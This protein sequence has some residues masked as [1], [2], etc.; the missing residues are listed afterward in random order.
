MEGHRFF[1]LVRWGEADVVLNRYL[2]L[3]SPK[4]QQALKDAFFIKGKHEYLPIP[5]SEIIN[6]S[7]SGL[8]TLRQNPGY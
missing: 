6:S 2:Q 4:R 7:K 5:E 1:D 8:P 3:E